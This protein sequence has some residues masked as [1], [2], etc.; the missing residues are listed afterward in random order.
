MVFS[1]IA[2]PRRMLNAKRR[3]K[4]PTALLLRLRTCE[5]CFFALLES[6]RLFFHWCVCT[7]S[8]IRMLYLHK[9]LLGL[10]VATDAPPDE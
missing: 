9:R 7:A 10:T 5:K 1:A 2:A 6:P 8:F 3:I 4:A